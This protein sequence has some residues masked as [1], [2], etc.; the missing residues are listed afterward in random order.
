MPIVSG[1]VIGGDAI[2]LVAGGAAI[3]MALMALQ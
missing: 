2:V 1:G 3:V